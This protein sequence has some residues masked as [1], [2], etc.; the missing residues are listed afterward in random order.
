MAKILEMRYKSFSS[1]FTFQVKLGTSVEV[2]EKFSR[3]EGVREGSL[4]YTAW[5]C[6]L[7]SPDAS[8][9]EI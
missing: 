9:G 8:S 7:V 3:P 5:K 1:L 2:Y 4:P 6:V